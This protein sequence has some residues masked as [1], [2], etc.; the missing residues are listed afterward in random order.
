MTDRMD[1]ID[2]VRTEAGGRTVVLSDWE[3]RSLLDRSL[4]QS[5]GGVRRVARRLVTGG[6]PDAPARIPGV[7][8]FRLE[9]KEFLPAPDIEAIA[10]A[11]IDRHEFG[12]EA[13]LTVTYL[14]KDK[15]GTTDGLPCFGKTIRL[16]G[17]N[18]HGIGGDFVIWL[19]ADNCRLSGFTAWQLEAL[20]FHELC[21]V[22]IDEDSGKAILHPHEFTGFRAELAEYGAWAPDLERMAATVKQLGFWDKEEG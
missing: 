5:V 21:H 13:D 18:K 17:L 10:Q 19:A 16:S 6:D 1:E 4:S 7:G 14:W 2:E 12:W 11:L 9:G 15:G 3:A 20:T 8:D 22:G